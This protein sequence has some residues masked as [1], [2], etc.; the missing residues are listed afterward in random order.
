MTQQAVHWHEGMFLRPQHF[1]AAERHVRHWTGLHSRLD[2]HYNWGLRRFDLDLDA[3]ANHRVQINQL[4]ARL[5]DGTLVALPGD[6]RL[7][8]C[9]LRGAFEKESVVTVYLGVPTLQ[10]S[11]ANITAATALGGTR[12]IVDELE[13]EDENTG[14]NPQRIQVRLLNASLLT[15][16]QDRAGF[17]TLPLVRVRRADRAEAAPELDDTYIPPVLACDAW[18]PLTDRILHPV[19]DRLGKKIDLLSQQI[20]SRAITF[21][22]QGQGDRQL[23]EQ[24]RVMNESYAPLGVQT[25]AQGVHPYDVYVEFCRLIGRLSVFGPERRPPQMPR[26]DHDDL[27]T[28]FWRAKQYI[29]ELLDVVIE[30]EYKERPF[31]GAGLRM[32]VSLE[33]AWLEAGRELYVGVQSPLTAEQTEK[34]LNRGLDMKIGSSERVDEIFRLGQAGLKFAYADR[35]P[36]ALPQRPGLCYFQIDRGAQTQEWDAVKHSLA[37]AIRLNENLISGNIQGQRTLTINTAG[38]TLQLQFVLLVTHG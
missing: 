16:S 4:E 35:P 27:G 26:Y 11:R 23:L 3:L 38:Q 36:R 15:S 30:P 18:Q 5:R 29:D 14:L 8:E 12:Y 17:E 1:Q 10:T 33:P 13:L 25:F 31:I 20:T 2:Q 37:L 28:C 6:V 32:Q 9:D 22:S 7:A 34:L 19:Y 24:L 21:D